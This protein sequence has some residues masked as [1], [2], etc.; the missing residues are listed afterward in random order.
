[1]AEISLA[2]L[3]TGR[4]SGINKCW[5]EA[6]SLNWPAGP[7]QSLSCNVHLCVCLFVCAIGCSFFFRSSSVGQSLWEWWLW[8]P[9][10]TFCGEIFRTHLVDNFHGQF[11]VDISLKIF[12]YV[13]PPK[14][15]LDILFFIFEAA[16]HFFNPPKNERKNN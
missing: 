13:F 16:K 1:M 3:K 6:I 14:I 5:Y 7:I 10:P 11:F 2:N 9:T 15:M 8:S 4:E 12:I